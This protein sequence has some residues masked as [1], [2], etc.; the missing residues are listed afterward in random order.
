M[1]HANRLTIH[2]LDAM[3]EHEREMISARTKAALEQ[4]KARGTKLG[5]PRWR[6]S[7]AKATAARKKTPAAADV[8]EILA[9]Y[10]SEGLSLRAIAAR[11]KE[12]ELKTPSGAHWYAS[13]VRAALASAGPE[14]RPGE[15]LP[16]AA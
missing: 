12:L 4:V 2:T 7:I 13:T 1:P 10:R 11:L 14:K 5:S 3:A 6:E 9:R 16:K 8:G 15:M